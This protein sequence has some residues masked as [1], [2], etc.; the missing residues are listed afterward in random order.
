MR[1]SHTPFIAPRLTPGA[2]VVFYRRFEEGFVPE[3]RRL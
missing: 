1:W 3:E 2:I